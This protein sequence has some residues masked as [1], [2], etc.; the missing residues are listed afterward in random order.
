MEGGLESPL[1]SIDENHL[2]ALQ[3]YYHDS[4]LQ[5]I[6]RYG[7]HN[8]WNEKIDINDIYSHWTNS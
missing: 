1:K 6:S 5:L 8:Q 2:S 3:D 7:I 4:N